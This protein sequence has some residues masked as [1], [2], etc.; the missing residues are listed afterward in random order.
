MTNNKK[1]NLET[2]LIREGLNRSQFGET[3]EPIY[4]TSS[5]VY[6]SPEQAEARFKGDEE[7]FIYSRYGNPTVQMFEDRL[8][9]IENADKCFATST[10]MA[11]VFASLM[12]QLEKGDKVVSSRALF[13]SIYQI[14]TKILPKYGIET[15]LVN[16]TDLNEWESAI[17][18]KT[19]VVFF[20]TPSNPTLE[21]IDIK[22]VCSL[23][24]KFGAK[25]IIDNVF[26]TPILQHPFE[27]GVDIVVYSGTK[28]IDGQGRSLGGA[29]I[30]DNEF[31]DKLL[32]PF[33]RHTGASMSPF[34][35]WIMLK[36][37]ETLKL[38][39]D[40]QSDNA[41]EIANYYKDNPN[42]VN[43]IYPS[44]S[45]HSQFELIKKQMEKG[46]TILTMV[47][48]GGKEE[49][50][51]IFNEL[52][53]IDI[54]NNLGDTKSIIT[55]PATT[56]HYSLGEEGRKEAGIPDGMIR[57]SVGLENVNDI[58]SD[59]DNAMKIY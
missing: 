26:A 42:I 46:G 4:M 5:Y 14:L 28:H 15:V 31:H 36:G 53:L 50:F 47:V 20:E 35:A 21:I 27:L 49:V 51:K 8:A 33:M 2:K 41:L 48:K 38:R 43:L 56:T 16:G 30:S 37:L 23:A 59:I 9:S 7:G 24:K 34:N 13:G 22:N 40:A 18:D 3:S 19:K 10:G 54:S 29:I 57:L 12:C 17:D 44:K 32:K 55:H 11:A 45:T 25:V 6:D 39:V 1:W 52:D 58:I